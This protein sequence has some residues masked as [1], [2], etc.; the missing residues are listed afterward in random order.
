MKNKIFM[1]FFISLFCGR[2]FALSQDYPCGPVEL[3]EKEILHQDEGDLYGLYYG[4]HGNYMIEVRIPW[5]LKSAHQE[6][7]CGTSGCAGSITH[8]TSGTKEYVTFFC[9]TINNDKFD[10]VKCYI[11]NSEKYL[12]KRY[13]DA[14]YKAKLCGK[15]YK[16][17]RL[18]ECNKCF[19]FVHDSRS[20]DY[21]YKMGCT[22]NNSDELYCMTG[23]IYSEDYKPNS[24]VTDFE[25][26]VDMEIYRQ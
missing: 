1:L 4:R 23:N 5:L 6:A 7:D 17:V 12:L 21:T 8:T 26:C 16:Y 14:E 20:E 15:Y 3:D 9:E 25:N 22:M 18:A 11:N 19:C 24:K 2:A 10:R 13:S